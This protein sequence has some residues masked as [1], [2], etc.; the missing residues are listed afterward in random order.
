MKKVLLY[1]VHKAAS[2]FLHSL[3]GDI[4]RV[5]R[6][7]HFS[8]NY[9]KM[10]APIKE[11]SWNSYIDQND[12]VFGPI[13]IFEAEP[14]IPADLSNYSVIVHTRDPRDVLTSL[15]YSHTYSHKTWEGGFNPSDGKRKQWEAMGIDEYVQKN[16]NILKKYEHILAHLWGKP[17]VIHVTYEEMVTDYSSWLKNILPAFSHLQFPKGS[18]IK[19]GGQKPSLDSLYTRLYK[20]YKED[21]TVTKEDIHSHK[22][23]VTPGDF[24]RK[25]NAESIA[26]LNL[27]F[28][29]VLQALNYSVD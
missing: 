21:F 14:N 27:K 7:D 6:L 1:T 3:I 13:R 20:K 2:M 15:Y 19:L 16:K 11:H 8:M 23:Q 18:F 17:G 4:S 10:F 25:L 29:A 5:Y 9:E 12:G 24:S 28:E 26:H 22:R